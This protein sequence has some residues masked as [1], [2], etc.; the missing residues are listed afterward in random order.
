MGED[1]FVLRQIKPS[2]G[3]IEELQ[4]QQVR[5]NI[6]K[7]LSKR[8]FVVSVIR[9]TLTYDVL[10]PGTSMTCVS[11][12][13]ISMHYDG[14]DPFIPSTDYT[15]GTHSGDVVINWGIGSSP[16]GGNLYWV[17]LTYAPVFSASGSD[18]ASAAD[19]T[20]DVAEGFNPETRVRNQ[21]SDV[22]GTP[23]AGTPI[24]RNFTFSP[25]NVNTGNNNRCRHVKV[26]N[27][28][29]G[30]IYDLLPETLSHKIF[31]DSGTG[32]Y[33]NYCNYE[34]SIAS[35]VRVATFAYADD[36]HSDAGGA[37]KKFNID[38][39][40]QSGITF[41]YPSGSNYRIVA[42]A[43]GHFGYY[44]P[45]P[46]KIQ[47]LTAHFTCGGLGH[48]RVSNGVSLRDLG[49]TSAARTITQETF[50]CSNGVYVEYHNGS[51]FAET[52][53]K[54]EISITWIPSIQIPE[55]VNGSNT[56]KFYIVS[57]DDGASPSANLSFDYSIDAE[58]VSLAERMQYFR[59]EA[60]DTARSA[61]PIACVNPPSPQAILGG[62]PSVGGVPWAE[63]HSK[64]INNV[65]FA[66][67][68]AEWEAM[69]SSGT[70]NDGDVIILVGIW[71]SASLETI[72]KKVTII[73]NPN[74]TIECSFTAKLFVQNVNINTDCF[75]TGNDG[76]EFHNVTFNRTVTTTITPVSCKFVGC[77]ISATN[78][79]YG[80]NN[81]E[82]SQDG[83]VF[84][85]CTLESDCSI[86]DNV[87]QGPFSVSGNYN[88][89]E[90]CYFDCYISNQVGQVETYL[91]AYG[92]DVS[93]NRNKLT[94]C[95]IYL[96]S[97]SANRINGSSHLYAV[98]ASGNYNGI[99]NNDAELAG[100][101]DSIT[102]A[103]VHGTGT[104]NQD[105]Y[106]VIA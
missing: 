25:N 59:E 33:T 15:I 12:A 55:L 18:I 9:G 79:Q 41:T 82:I 5:E 101:W 37:D 46:G 40:S 71:A 81:L 60:I 105:G 38:V 72:N 85:G 32:T 53:T 56:L 57:D 70:V 21:L 14:H 66:S 97:D 96:Y 76:S 67:S 7:I 43:G 102:K 88:K 16:L 3:M 73:G 83:N 44:I 47:S 2:T 103:A 77:Y 94:G 19:V 100:S 91:A 78:S 24:I 35:G 63:I 22:A 84:L 106:N 30:K 80:Y 6:D 65:K 29:T 68:A 62:D 104:S 69:W 64:T 28:T 17:C 86:V 45:L 90:A 26:E 89:F 23:D 75:G 49:D 98:V 51:G 74:V 93:G 1:Y 27:A 36:G 99:V 54:V 4:S 34:F 10:C 50:P 87:Q 39:Y 52:I 92:I 8:N 11:V 42:A 61:T 31:G 20:I 95:H 48:V 13:W 58:V